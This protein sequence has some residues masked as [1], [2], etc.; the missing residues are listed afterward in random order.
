[1]PSPAQP[2]IRGAPIRAPVLDGRFSRLAPDRAVEGR[3]QGLLIESEPRARFGKA[4]GRSAN[5]ARRR[6]PFAWTRMLA[7]PIAILICLTLPMAAVAR[8]PIVRTLP[9]SAILFAAIGLPVNLSGVTLSD[10][11][12]S[13]GPDGDGSALVVEG[14]LTNSGRRPA[15]VPDLDIE[16]RSQGN[17][18]LY[19]W[20]IKASRP[21]F[22][23]GGEVSFQARLASPPLLGRQVRVT[24]A[25]AG[26]PAAVASR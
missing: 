2:D 8:V 12:S 23:A 22:E 15:Q 26:G 13:V 24:V 18:L 21:E 4:H 9:Q 10:V 11:T 1:M 14:R 3:T 5:Q 25:Q 7:A 20:S 17:D 19:R 6:A 16:I